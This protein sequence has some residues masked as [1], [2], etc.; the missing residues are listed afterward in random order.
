[1]MFWN[2]R[3]F[4]YCHLFLRLLGF[5]YLESS[6][7]TMTTGTRVRVE[8]QLDVGRHHHSTWKAMEVLLRLIEAVEMLGAVDVVDV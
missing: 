6:Q 4:D 5:R 3:L 1:M 8:S 7:A 2:S